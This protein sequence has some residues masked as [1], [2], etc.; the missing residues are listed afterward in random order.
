MCELMKEPRKLL[1]FE[2]QVAEHC[3]LKCINCNHFAPLAKN[4]FLDIENYTRDCER[5]SVL[6]GSEIEFIN[7][8][9]GEPLLHPQIID[10]MKITRKNFQ[11]GEIRLVTNGLLLSD[12][13]QE[14]WGACKANRI[15]LHITKYPVN[16]DYTYI[17][18][19]ASLNG[20]NLDYYGGGDRNR[21]LRLP[22]DLSGKFDPA[23]NF[24]RCTWGNFWITLCGNGRLYTCTKAACAHHL[25]DYFNLDMELDVQNSVDIYRVNSADEL[26]QKLAKPIPFCR[27]CDLSVWNEYEDNWQISSKDKYEWVSFTYSKEDIQYLKNISKV[28]IFGAGGWGTATVRRLTDKGIKITAILVSSKKNNKDSID[29]IPVIEL[30]QL[31]TPDKNDVCILALKGKVKSE[32]QSILYQKGFKRL[33]P[34]LHEQK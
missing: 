8:M 10:I 11:R 12:M 1:R 6:F 32:I 17:E 19:E 21:M 4:Q 31:D 14:F 20:V 15:E 9:G 24:R 5:L 13:K 7:L 3:N 27:Y 30:E 29:H 18:K 23:D 33:I 28:Y 25:K 34:L 2:V 26:M 22:I 16:L